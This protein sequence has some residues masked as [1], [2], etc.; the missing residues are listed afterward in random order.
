[1]TSPLQI[2]DKTR[3]L[4]QALA[5][6]DMTDGRIVLATAD[7]IRR[8]GKL[9]TDRL[10]NAFERPAVELY[11]EIG[12]TIEAIRQAGGSPL[13]SGAGPSVL[14]LHDSETSALDVARRLR[15]AGRDASIA[16]PVA[17]SRETSIAQTYRH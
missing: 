11:P 13:L 2:P 15:S 8:G 14:S 16:R 10:A 1:V 17:R 12:A 3:R 4:Y 9:P 7:E 6:A 5:P